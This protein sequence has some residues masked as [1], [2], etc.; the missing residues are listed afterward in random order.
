MPT[1]YTFS[2]IMPV[3]PQED[4]CGINCPVLRKSI[5]AV[6][7]ENARRLL[8]ETNKSKPPHECTGLIIRDPSGKVYMT[9]Y[10]GPSEHMSVEPYCFGNG[11]NRTKS[12]VKKGHQLVAEWHT[13][14]RRRLCISATDE[15]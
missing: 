13:H 4:V 8:E 12:E 1:D 15:M 5:D 7:L 6:I 9:Q 10:K 14:P 2:Y 11:D 3:C